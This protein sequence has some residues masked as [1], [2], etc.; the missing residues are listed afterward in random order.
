VR[1]SC[2]AAIAWA[3]ADDS[4]SLEN[5]KPNA[6]AA[7]HHSAKTSGAAE[8]LGELG[9]YELLEQIGRGGQGVVFRARQKSLNRIVALKVIGLG[10]WAT[11]ADFKRF[12]LEAEAAARLEHPGIVPIHEVGE[13]DGSCYF[14]MKFI[15]GGQL[16]A[17]A[18]REPMAVRRAVELI[19][20]VARTV[21]YAH[22]HGI[23][24]RDIKPGNILLDGK[25]EPHLTDF[26]LA[27]LMESESTLTRTKEVMGT[28]SYMAPEQA[29]GN[30]AA[31]GSVTDVYGLGAVF[32]Q[33]LTGQPPFA[34]GTTYETIQLLL[35]TE[36][37][38]PRLLNSKIDRDLSTI[39]LKCL[40]KDPQRRYPSALALAE[41][42]ERWLKHEPIQAR[43]S[44]RLEHVWRWCKRKPLVA[45]LIAA[46]I[47][48]VAVAMAGALWE[49]PRVQQERVLAR[50]ANL[51]EQEKA[52]L[53]AEQ[54]NHPAAYDAYLRGRAFPGSWHQ[55]GAIRLFQEAV[56]SDPNF[57]QA[58]AYLSI[59]QS[60]CYWLGTDP[61]P[62]RLTAAKDALDR[63]LALDPDLPETR[64]ALGYY[65]FHCSRD[66][67]GALAEFRQAET[68]FPNS[69]DVI[70]AIAALQRRLGH[71][72]EAIV[73]QRRAVGL[74]PRNFHA[75]SD[76]VATYVILRRFPEALAEADRVLA[77][78]PTNVGA[79]SQKAEIFL[80][81][82][83][84]QAMEPLLAN[85]RLDPNL[86]AVYALLQ[87]R[88]AEATEILSKTLATETDR[89]TRNIEKLLL[90]LSQQRAGDVAA[91]HATYHDAAQDL[92]RQLE[93]AAADSFAAGQTH[94]FLGRAYAGLGEAA[95]A[96][97]EGQKAMTIHPTSKDP[98][99]GPVEEEN[100]AQIYALLAD[101]DHAIPILKRL[102]QI[103]YAGA[104]TPAGL[105]L[106]PVWDQIRNDARFQQLAAEKDPVSSR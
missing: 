91:A 9:D 81:T 37:R 4:G 63:A 105:R 65:R 22:E 42:L 47:M 19:T 40:D 28:P 49:L 85:P 67:P 106:D 93:K 53:A 66:F 10:H 27:R 45:S 54:T 89:D 88:Y 33:L 80:A 36:P 34:G 29:M 30:N 59:A 84:L 46:L 102:L 71:W 3:K 32:Y 95:S 51:S 90:G 41:D 8:M 78:N 44:S 2:A 21:Q 74:D 13:H 5:I 62:A 35:E 79:L 76:L 98:V 18:K 103:P 15:E 68:V 23:L 86:R 7:A 87:R 70:E 24:H 16:D 61:S 104:I 55:E 14:S 83:D 26:G 60:F 77:W 72:D 12:R 82:G 31:V 73:G 50:R 1:D 94:G 75:S 96:I 101:A 11:E 64:L 69:A 39:C 97:A 100:M 58:W 43:H 56:K 38:P 52:R 6:T 20:K 92:N 57:V 25:G 17:V 48:V 99:E